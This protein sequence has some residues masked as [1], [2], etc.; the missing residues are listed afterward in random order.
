MFT[1]LA[2]VLFVLLVALA[3]GLGLLRVSTGR[4][5]LLL[6]TLV[7]LAFIGP[8]C[9]TYKKCLV[10]GCAGLHRGVWEMDHQ[11]VAQKI[12]SG[13][14]KVTAKVWLKGRETTTPDIKGWQDDD[15]HLQF[16]LKG[17]DIKDQRQPG[18]EDKN[19]FLTESEIQSRL[20]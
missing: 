4:K 7:S 9:S 1:I 14:V 11:M 10:P 17:Y 12:K 13:N 2:V 16:Y 3:T 15:R 8:G 20:D 5:L 19:I 18:W 6:G